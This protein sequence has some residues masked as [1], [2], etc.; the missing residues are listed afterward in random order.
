MG[1][2]GEE[3]REDKGRRRRRESQNWNQLSLLRPVFLSMLVILQRA[4][5][6]EEGSKG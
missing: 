6:L 4:G 2:E 1:G 3:E 5:T